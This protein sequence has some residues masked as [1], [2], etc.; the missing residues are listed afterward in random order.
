MTARSQPNAAPT[1]APSVVSTAPPTGW[2]AAVL[3]RIEREL[4]K[5]VGPVARVLVRRGARDHATV[6]ALT[7]TLAESLANS[8]D[9][10]AFLTVVNGPGTPTPTPRTIEPSGTRSGGTS[11]PG[12]SRDPISQDDLDRATR[13]L[14][15][16]MG[17]IAKVLVKRTAAEGLGRRDFLNRLAQHVPSESDRTRFL[18]EAGL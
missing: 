12:N 8:K 5:Y 13:A 2:D 1:T 7:T 16:S 17:P 15:K 10:D 4:T 14:T 9:R 6:V 3:A 18:R 11:A